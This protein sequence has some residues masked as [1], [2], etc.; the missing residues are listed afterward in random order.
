[1]SGSCGEDVLVES[2]RRQLVFFGCD[3]SKLKGGKGR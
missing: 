2:P 1:M 3:G